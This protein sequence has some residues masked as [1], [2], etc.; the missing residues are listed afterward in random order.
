MAKEILRNRKLQTKIEP[1]LEAHIKKSRKY[2]YVGKSMSEY[3]RQALIAMS[4]YKE[5]EPVW[6]TSGLK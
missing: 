1:Q 4:K 6:N 5:K 2:L 3:I